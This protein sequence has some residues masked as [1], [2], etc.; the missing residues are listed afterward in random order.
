MAVAESS[1]A[2]ICWFLVARSNAGRFL[3][4]PDLRDARNNWAAFSRSVDED[5]GGAA[6]FSPASGAS[7]GP[8]GAKYN[9]DIPDSGNP[10][11]S[12]YGESLVL[13]YEVAASLGWVEQ[14]S[15]L[16]GCRV[17]NYAVNSNST[18]Q[19]YLRFT[20][21]NNKTPFVLL[22]IDPGTIIDNL[23][24]YGG[25][26]R[27]PLGPYALKGR[28]LLDSSDR[29]KW[30]SRPR[31]DEDGFL[32]LHRTP[33]ELV[34][35]DYF[36]PDTVEGP[37]TPHFPHSLTLLRVALLARVRDVLAGRAEWRG[38]Y[39]S[40]HPSG[41]LRVLAA[42]CQ[43]FVQHADSLGEPV[44]IIVLPVA[45][46]FREQAA[47]GKFEYAPLVARLAA[48]GVEVFDPG[49]AML[50]ALAGNSYC[51]LFTRP[52]SCE[53]HYS[54]LGNT[55]LANLVAAELWRRGFVGKNK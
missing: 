5:I 16:L 6:I 41:A 38:F 55:I 54:V 20:R 32:A 21:A 48:K 31:L 29:L 35:Y 2:A 1:A 30:L 53:G 13:G 10:C 7:R 50:D 47:Y 34:P 11:G 33:A 24:Q 12:A 22:G 40:D 44:L 37:V 51:E 14:L 27:P 46:S 43:A 25:F 15:R 18:D 17:A 9:P 45:K 3:W 28:F 4:N 52:K 26:L 8:T 39:A 49:P 23:S 42:I 36:L 19:T